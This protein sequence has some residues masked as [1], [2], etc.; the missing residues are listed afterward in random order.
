MD[1]VMQEEMDRLGVEREFRR[2][3]GR[4]TFDCF[5]LRSSGKGRVYCSKGRLLGRAKDGSMNELS[6]LRGITSRICKGCPDY[7][8]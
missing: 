6:A 1:K 3:H 4:I 2:R 5:E 8:D 7:N